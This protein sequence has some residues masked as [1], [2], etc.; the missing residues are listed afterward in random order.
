MQ[1][2]AITNNNRKLFHKSFFK[3]LNQEVEE[4]INIE[5]YQN[6]ILIDSAGWHYENSFNKKLTKLETILTAKNF[7]LDQTKFDALIDDRNRDNLIWPN[8]NLLDSVLVFDRSQVLKY[9]TI[10]Q[11]NVILKQA[12][13]QYCPIKIILRLNLTFIDDNRFVNRIQNLSCL[14]IKN[15]RVEKFMFDLMS[16]IFYAEFSRIP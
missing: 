16:D 6:L 15:Y 13:D 1:Q 8:V 3:Q 10:E 5:N 2:T 9:R 7:K 4:L 14:E 11:L 12:V